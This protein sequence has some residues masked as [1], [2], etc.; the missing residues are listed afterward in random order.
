M[1]LRVC[2]GVPAGDSPRPF[3]AAVQATFL[4]LVAEAWQLPS[5]SATPWARGCTAWPSAWRTRRPWP[6][7]ERKAHER[8]G[9][10]IAIEDRQVAARAPSDDLGPTLHDEIERL[11]SASTASRSCSATSKA[12]R[13]REQLRPWDGRLARFEAERSPAAVTCCARTVRS[14]GS[15]A[16]S[17][18]AAA[19]A[20]EPWRRPRRRS[21]RRCTR[22]DHA[23]GRTIGGRCPG[24]RCRPGG[25][26]DR[27]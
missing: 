19:A 18:V 21:R 20:A 2:R 7:L 12:R 15:A 1:V 16:T 5:G 9:G 24:R 17:V 22:G 3:T 8:K 14:A 23:G 6:P 26:I 11:R 10:E 25:C 27:G 4:I 13:T